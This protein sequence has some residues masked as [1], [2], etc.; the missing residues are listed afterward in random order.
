[1]SNCN[2]QTYYVNNNGNNNNNN[3]R[4]AYAV[5][6][7]RE[8]RQIR[9]GESR[10]QNTHTGSCHLPPYK[11]GNKTCDIGS[12]TV[13]VIRTRMIIWKKTIIKKLLILTT[14]IKQ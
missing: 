9:V 1:M 13:P 3:C 11:E 12:V 6:P 10:K 8:K 4:N 7:D 14:C 2:Y 5:A